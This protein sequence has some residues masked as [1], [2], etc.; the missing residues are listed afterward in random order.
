MMQGI[1]HRRIVWGRLDPLAGWQSA[2]VWRSGYHPRVGL[3]ARKKSGEVSFDYRLEGVGPRGTWLPVRLPASA[4]AALGGDRARIPVIGTADGQP[5]RTSA[6]P[7]G[8]S[9]MFPFNKDMQA[10][11]GKGA[12][13]RVRFILR[14]DD[15]PRTVE[16]PRDLA[17][18]LGSPRAARERF[19]ALS[20][21]HRREYVQWIASAVKPETRAR[22]IARAVEMILGDE[23]LKS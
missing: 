6:A 15:A 21:T 1:C 20:Y 11:T 12:G 10:A 19:D 7:M 23:R 13:D 2:T 3:K 8:G 16:V 4:H 18:A 14:R 5:I 17:V 22:R 9:H